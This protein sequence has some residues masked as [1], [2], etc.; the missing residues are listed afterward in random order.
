MRDETPAARC[1]NDGCGREAVAG[2]RFCEACCLEW[3]LF[4]RDTRP[5]ALDGRTGGYPELSS[6]A[7]AALINGGIGS[8]RL[9]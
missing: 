8:V 9:R 6:D 5:V 2:E 7:A 1:E 4:R 3:A